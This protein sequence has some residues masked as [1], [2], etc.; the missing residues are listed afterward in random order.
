MLA[1]PEAKN[2]EYPFYI[3]STKSNIGLDLTIAG[4]SCA[5]M[6]APDAAKVK[7]IYLRL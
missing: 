6:G 1:N 5:N 2:E 3:T 4:I 7:A